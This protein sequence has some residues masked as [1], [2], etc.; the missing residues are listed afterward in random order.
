[1]SLDPKRKNFKDQYKIKERVLT[2][3]SYQAPQYLSGF[4]LQYFQALLNW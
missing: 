2:K 3:I 1:M 4:E